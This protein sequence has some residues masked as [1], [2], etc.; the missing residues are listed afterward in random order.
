M[1]K[2]NSM[3]FL[4]VLAAL[5]AAFAFQSCNNAAP[6]TQDQME[7]YWVLKTMEGEDAKSQFAGA[8]P[9]LKFDF[10]N[11]M[12]SGTGG[13]NR[14]SG[15]YTYENGVFSAPNL[16]STRMLCVEDNKEGEFLLALSNEN[17]T[18][19]LENGLLTIVHDGKAVL[20]FEKGTEPADSYAVNAESLS[21]TWVLKTIDGVDVSEKF[22]GELGK[23]PTATFDF[24]KNI[25]NG[26]G[27]CNNYGA[28]FQLEEGGRL[29]VSHPAAT[30]MAC[31][32]M[33]G[34]AQFFQAITDTS[35]LTLP[36][37]NVLQLA[38]NDIA[39]LIFEKSAE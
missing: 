28:P 15:A 3:K 4:T 30:M 17:N 35:V 23:M 14:Y 39:L 13:C 6:L 7:G 38:K 36:N 31:P 22:S 32:N 10:E 21:G 1:K 25:I 8:L 27:G 33:Q 29:I 37:A 9:T 20:Q 26:N 5:L 18:L 34:E 19:T 24:E 2:V 16:A 11:K 12:V